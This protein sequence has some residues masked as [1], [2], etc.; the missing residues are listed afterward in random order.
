MGIGALIVT[1]YAAQF[2][3]ELKRHEFLHKPVRMPQFLDAVER[4]LAKLRP[5]AQA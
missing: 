4:V 2:G 1:G 5:P 3:Q